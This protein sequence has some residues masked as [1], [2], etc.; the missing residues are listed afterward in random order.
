MGLLSWLFGTSKAD[1][2]PR[3]SETGRSYRRESSAN[4]S[5]AYTPYPH[6]G[7]DSGAFSSHGSSAFDGGG[8]CDGGGG[9]G[10]GGGD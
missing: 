6:I 10:C 2:T 3:S 4:D 7:A 5:F 9:G 1:R 8:S